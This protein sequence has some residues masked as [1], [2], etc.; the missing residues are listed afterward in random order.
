[1]ALLETEM[2]PR[3]REIYDVLHD[4]ISGMSCGVPLVAVSDIRKEFGVGQATVEKAF[5]ALESQ[6]FIE[7]KPRKTECRSV[8]IPNGFI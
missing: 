4:R 6:G 2:S 3:A 1:M 8:T 5:T 7:R